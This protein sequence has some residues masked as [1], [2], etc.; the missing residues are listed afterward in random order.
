VPAALDGVSWNERLYR[1]AT[2]AELSAPDRSILL[3]APATPLA[4]TQLSRLG[5]KTREDFTS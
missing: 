2:R 1:F 3:R 4:R 5:W